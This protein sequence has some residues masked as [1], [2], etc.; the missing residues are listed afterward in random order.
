MG[1]KS[2]NLKRKAVLTEK[3]LVLTKK[4]EG[5]PEDDPGSARCEK[6]S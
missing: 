6:I 5:T 4:P 2:L 3:Q 1:T